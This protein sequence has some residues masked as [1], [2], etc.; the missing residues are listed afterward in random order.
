MSEYLQVWRARVAEASV[1]RLLAVRPAAIAEAQALCP[2][3]LGAELVRVE[4]DGEGMDADDARL[5]VERHATSKIARPEDL[6]AIRTLGFRGEALPSIASVSHFVLMTRARGAESGTDIRMDGG[7]I[8]SVRETGTREGTAVE[9]SDLFYN[10]PARRKFLK[11]DT[12]EATQ[13]SRLM[14]QFALG[15]PEIGWVLTS[16]SRSLL[17]CPPAVG[18]PERLTRLRSER[19]RRLYA[20]ALASCSSVVA[21]SEHEVESLRTEHAHRRLGFQDSEVRRWF[22]AAG[23]VPGRILRLDGDPLTVCL[24]TATRAANDAETATGNAAREMA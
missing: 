24:W 22:Q 14:T 6:S 18:L 12:A 4:D 23:L 7:T 1:A 5:A 15:Y 19:M 21:Y 13:I 2:E 11:S 20:S 3:L 16:G 9:V 17:E 10:L 8:A